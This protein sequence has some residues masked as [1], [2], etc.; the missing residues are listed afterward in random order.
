VLEEEDGRVVGQLVDRLA[1]SAAPVLHEDGT[2]EGL[3]LVFRDVT[4]DFRL[5]EENRIAAIA[6]DTHNAMAI[7][8]TEGH[9]LR[10]N[11]AFARLTGYTAEGIRGHALSEL[12]SNAIPDMLPVEQCLNQARESAWSGRRALQRHDGQ[13]LPVW[14]TINAVR[15]EQNHITHFVASFSDL[16][17]LDQTTRAL[18]ESPTDATRWKRRRKSS[19]RCWPGSPASS[20]G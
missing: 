20:T 6:F 14:A 17:E 1:A 2:L 11:P 16:S 19:R 15:D 7:T 13:T 12:D 4:E 10:V 5:R 9:I 18:L 3:I 8:D